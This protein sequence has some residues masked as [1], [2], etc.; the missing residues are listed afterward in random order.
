VA[1]RA[2]LEQPPKTEDEVTSPPRAI[3]DNVVAAFG[4]QPRGA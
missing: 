1:G 2:I 4:N 3:T